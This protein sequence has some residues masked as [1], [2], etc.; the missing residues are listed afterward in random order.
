[1]V[2]NALAAATVGHLLGISG[3]E[4]KAGLEAFEPVK[5]RMSIL[6]TE[7]GVHIINDTY[8]A[9][10]AAVKVAIE[11]LCS[12]KAGQRA[13][14][15]FADMLELGDRSE[16]LHMDVGAAVGRSEIDR[17]YLTGRFSDAVQTGAVRKNFHVDDIFIGA[18]DDIFKDLTDW[19]RPGDWVLVKGSRGM[20]MEDVVDRL[21]A[22]GKVS[23]GI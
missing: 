13:V 3:H 15:V 14:L 7:N 8:N 18:K 12:L 2:S 19:L 9:N 16:A 22:W 23:N 21:V 11:T 20:S 6:E 5:G 10:P 17:L 1:M 4:I